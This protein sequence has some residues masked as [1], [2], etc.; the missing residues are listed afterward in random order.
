[1]ENVKALYCALV[2]TLAMGVVLVAVALLL[3]RRIGEWIAKAY[4]EREVVD[5]AKRMAMTG[6]FYGSFVILL[7]GYE[8]QRLALLAPIAAVWLVGGI[9]VSYVFMKRLRTPNQLAGRD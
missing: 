8:S 9:Y 5:L 2:V 7:V 6:G 4:R 1:M 3:Q